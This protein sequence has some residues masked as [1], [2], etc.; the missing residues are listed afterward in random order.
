MMRDFRI[1]RIFEG[2]SEI[3]R[4]FI[5]REAVD[6]HLR[7][8]GPLVEGDLSLAGKLK[9]LPRV[10]GFY[11]RWYPRQWVTRRRGYGRFG[12]LSGHLKFVEKS[13]RRLARTLFHKM[14]RYGA[15]LQRK[16][17]VLFRGVDIATELFAMAAVVCRIQMMRRTGREGAEQ[18]VELADLYCRLARRRVQALFEE[19]RSN[20]DVPMYRVARRILAGELEWMEEGIVG[21]QEIEIPGPDEPECP[22]P[23][24]SEEPAGVSGN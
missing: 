7:V 14:V 17:M 3:M 24:T 22:F 5:A 6:Q 19:M 23:H 10:L 20:E 8:A 12:A 11:S 9:L 4:L 13:S 2:S 1:N 15:G 21:L 18:S 16:Q